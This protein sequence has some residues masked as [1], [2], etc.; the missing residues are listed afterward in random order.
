LLEAKLF[1]TT[2]GKFIW[3]ILQPIFYTLRPLFVN[4]KTPIPWEFFNT[5]VQLSFDFAVYYFFG[6]R[7]CTH[8]LVSVVN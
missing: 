5:T 7:T 3:V 6:E 2:F 1:C 4:P 8:A